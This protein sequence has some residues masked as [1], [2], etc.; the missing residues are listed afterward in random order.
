M[1]ANR[2]LITL[3]LALAILFLSQFAAEIFFLTGPLPEAGKRIP[4]PAL[5]LKALSLSSR[6]FTETAFAWLEAKDENA[7]KKSMSLLRHSLQ[8][9][10]LDYQA[11]YYLAK[12]YLQYS[13]VSNG[14][15]DLGLR[16]LKRAARIRGSNKQVALDCARVFFSLWPLLEDAD[17]TFAHD[18]LAA[19]MPSLSWPEFSPLVEMWSLYVQDAPLLMELL[20]RK[21]DF[22]GP[23]ANQLVAAEIPMAQRRELLALH[24]VHTLDALERRYNELSLQGDIGLADARSLLNQLLQLKGYYRLKP[25]SGFVPEK[26]AK[27]RRLLLL[28]V[29]DGLLGDPQA[30]AD[31]K[32]APLLR[33]YILSY[34]AGHSGLT[35]LDELQKAARKK[36]TFSGKTISLPFI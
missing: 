22:F 2:S 18:L 12:A 35:D 8:R 1:K 31:A 25:D 16:E 17:K 11:R 19:V 33:G 36:K 29:I 28:K 4:Q 23:I 13:T 3:A 24:E 14:Y 32:T 26:F 7:V 6:I 21:P 10:P 30:Q 9:N 27:L 34:I 20:K 15:F 5:D